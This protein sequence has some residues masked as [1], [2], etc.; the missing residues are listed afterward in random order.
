[1]AKAK[2]TAAPKKVQTFDARSDEAL[3]EEV[4]NQLLLDIDVLKARQEI[5]ID[6]FQFVADTVRNVFGLQN[7]ALAYDAVIEKLRP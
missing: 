7:L 4:I 1:M 5:I 2:K 6:G 3:R